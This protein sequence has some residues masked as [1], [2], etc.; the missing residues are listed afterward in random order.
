MQKKKKVNRIHCIS[1]LL[2][3]NKLSPNPETQHL[4]ITSIYH[5]ARFSRG[6]DLGAASVGSPRQKGL[7][8][9]GALAV[10]WGGTPRSLHGAGASTAKKAPSRG[11]REG[12]PLPATR[13]SPRGGLSALTAWPL[14][15]PTVSDSRESREEGA[16][17]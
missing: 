17:A 15:S 10:C 8:C 4:K 13:R 14:A 2:P 1:Y 3:C 7:S 9:R 16:A 6:R 12:L 11:R 5:L